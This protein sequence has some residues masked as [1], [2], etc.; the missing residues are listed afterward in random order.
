MTSPRANP[1]CILRGIV[2]KDLSDCTSI[3]DTPLQPRQCLDIPDFNMKFFN[4]HRF[5]GDIAWLC[6][7]TDPESDSEDDEDI[8]SA[9]NWLILEQ[10][11]TCPDFFTKE[12]G[13][14]GHV[15]VPKEVYA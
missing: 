12:T 6:G 8:L 9:E 14:N 4:L 11:L 7:G 15:Y 2:N 3:I 10:E 1:T 13:P 5:I